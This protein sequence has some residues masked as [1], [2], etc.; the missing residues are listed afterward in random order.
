MARGEESRG[1]GA[2]APHPPIL[3]P[4]RR[5]RSPCTPPVHLCAR[6]PLPTRVGCCAQALGE[7]NPNAKQLS[8]KE[9]QQMKDEK[10]GAGDRLRKQGAKANKFDAKAAGVKANKKNGLM[11]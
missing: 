5:E 6:R 10:R 4:R 11:H 9:M 1:G 7:D 3:A 2:T 8:K